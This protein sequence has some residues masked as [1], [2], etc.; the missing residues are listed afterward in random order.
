MQRANGWYWCKVDGGW[1]P[2]IWDN[3]FNLVGSWYV[4]GRYFRD[5]ELEVGELIPDHV[6]EQKAQE[7]VRQAMERSYAGFEWERPQVTLDGRF[8]ADELEAMAWCMRNDKW[9]GRV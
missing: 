3:G 2:T 6:D 8:T 1:V 9:P 7:L 4:Y 5:E